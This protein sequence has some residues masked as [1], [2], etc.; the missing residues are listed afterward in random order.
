MNYAEQC[1]KLERCLNLDPLRVVGGTIAPPTT[2]IDVGLALGLRVWHRFR[3]RLLATLARAR[4][5]QV[6][7]R[8]DRFGNRYWQAYDPATGRSTTS[9]SAA[10]LRLWLEER[11]H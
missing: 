10:E 1:L 2:T 9:G 8:V 5:V 7:Q 3:Q 11:R 4:D 6:W